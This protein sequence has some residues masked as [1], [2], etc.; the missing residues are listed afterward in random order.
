MMISELLHVLIVSRTKSGVIVITMIR[1]SPHMLTLTC[2]G[3]G[4]DPSHKSLNCKVPCKRK[5]PRH[6]RTLRKVAVRVLQNI[7]DNAMGVHLNTESSQL[8]GT[9][10]Q[11]SRQINLSYTVL[12]TNAPFE[13]GHG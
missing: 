13:N 3:E 12:H 1:V 9:N 10:T 7:M 6:Q 4:G 11:T 5:F 2:V 8:L